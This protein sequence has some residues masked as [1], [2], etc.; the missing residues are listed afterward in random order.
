M[1]HKS[2]F[3]KTLNQ[4]AVKMGVRSVIVLLMM[5]QVAQA[6]FSWFGGS[7]KKKQHEVLLANRAIQVEATQ[8]INNMYNFE[9]E[10]AE[11]D[12]NC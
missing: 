9:Y 6:Q 10:A 4:I 2:Y 8:A 3:M 1:L 12:F 5:S 11:R 7:T